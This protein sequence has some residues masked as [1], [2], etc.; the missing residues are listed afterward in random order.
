LI[1]DSLSKR[2]HK[3]SKKN[4]EELMIKLNDILRAFTT[5]PSVS[6]RSLSKSHKIG[7]KNGQNFDESVEDAGELKR[8]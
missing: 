6:S 2:K 3:L 8:L 7:G 1:L 4:T 5:N